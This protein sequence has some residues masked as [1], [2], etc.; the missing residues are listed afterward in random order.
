MTALMF[1]WIQFEDLELKYVYFT[2]LR[3]KNTRLMIFFSINFV[4]LISALFLI[5]LC[6]INKTNLL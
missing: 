6:L 5:Y 3:A 1:K 4:A 2:A